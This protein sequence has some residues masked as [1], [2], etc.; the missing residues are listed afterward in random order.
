LGDLLTRPQVIPDCRESGIGIQFRAGVE[1]NNRYLAAHLTG[2]TIPEFRIWLSLGGFAPTTNG[3]RSQH[4]LLN[5]EVARR[6]DEQLRV[7]EGAALW[8]ESGAFLAHC[9]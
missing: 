5:S 4:E 2:L 1:W 9:T 6:S 7:H 3:V 8:G